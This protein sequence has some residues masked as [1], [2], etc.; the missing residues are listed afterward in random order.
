MELRSRRMLFRGRVNERPRLVIIGSSVDEVVRLE[1]KPD[2][3]AEV[4]AR[5]F[6]MRPQQDADRVGG[7]PP[8]LIFFSVHQSTA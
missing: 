6:L 8:T 1:A 4:A 5:V 3:D 2:D 7:S